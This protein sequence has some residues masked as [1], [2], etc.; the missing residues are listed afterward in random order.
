MCVGVWEGDTE[1]EVHIRI[2]T[3]IYVYI[4]IHI[5]TY[6]AAVSIMHQQVSTQ[7]LRSEVVNTACAVG[8]IP[9][10]HDLHAAPLDEDVGNSACVHE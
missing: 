2:Y 1:T 5:Y 9:E 6:E 4:H 8:H 7:F 10:H 3:Y